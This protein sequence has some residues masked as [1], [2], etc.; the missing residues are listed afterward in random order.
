MMNPWYVVRVKPNRERLVALSL[1]GRNLEV[2]LPFQK[3]MSARRNI[4]LIEIPL[5]PGYVFSQFVSALHP[6]GPDLPRRHQY[7]LL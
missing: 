6:C 4:G 2:F 5:F 7:H 1:S 3:R